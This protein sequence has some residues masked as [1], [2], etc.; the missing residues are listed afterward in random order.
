MKK[1]L[2][3]SLC[4]FLVT[5]VFAAFAGGGSEG[6]KAEAK[7]IS[8]NQTSSAEHPWQKASLA[9]A[10][11]VEEGTQGRYS[12]QVYANATLAQG[13]YQVMMEMIQA[14]TIQVGVESLTV[15]AAYNQD[16]SILN[17]PFLFQ[18]VP[19]T[20]RLLASDVPVWKKWMGQFEKSNLV[21]LAGAPR[22]MRQLNNNQRIIKSPADMNGMKFRVPMNQFYVSIFEALGA[23][24][25]PLPSSEIYSSIQLGT[26]NG[27]DNSV[28][29]QYDFKTHE[30]AKFFTVINYIADASF[31]FMNKDFYYGATAADQ[32]VFMDAGKTFAETN[33]REDTTYYDVAMDAMKK[34]GVQFYETPNADKK[35]FQDKL[36]GFYKDLQAKYSPEDWKAFHDA[37]A[38]AAKK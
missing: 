7:K 29:T 35:A 26:V 18:D 27:E 13:N 2:V 30:V 1:I 37:V 21:I 15:L 4:T 36:A 19:H 31:L 10:K 20:A 38:A 6:G 14:G 24:P 11:Q 28:Q 8:L 23:K 16:V 22:P 3:M 9:W 25:V 32:K 17:E 12:V 33:V 34:S 5:G